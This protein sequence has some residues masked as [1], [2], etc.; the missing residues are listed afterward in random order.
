[1][2]LARKHSPGERQEQSVMSSTLTWFHN[3]KD[4]YPPSFYSPP[5]YLQ[6]LEEKNEKEDLR[7]FTSG[8]MVKNPPGHAGGAGSIPGRGASKPT[9]L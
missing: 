9:H 6:F 3:W 1:M 8:P 7:D 5:L 2:R 4:F